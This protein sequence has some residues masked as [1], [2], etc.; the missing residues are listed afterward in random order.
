M[1]DPQPDSA[2]SPR[3]GESTRRRILGDAHV[4]RAI[5][6]T[7]D[8]D[9]PFQD[10]ITKVAW[11]GVWSRPGLDDRTRHLITIALLAGLGREHELALHLRSIQ[12]TGTSPEDVREALLHVAVYAGVPAA[13]HAMSLA[14]SIFA[15]LPPSTASDA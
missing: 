7:T 15:S 8:F 1:P 11:D 5:A 10:F 4:N 14:K 3:P 6:A 2:S 12:N 9:A 13:N